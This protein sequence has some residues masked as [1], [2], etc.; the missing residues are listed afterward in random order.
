MILK[1]EDSMPFFKSSNNIKL[2]KKGSNAHTVHIY[3]LLTVWETMPFLQCNAK[4]KEP[5]QCS[6]LQRKYVFL[7]PNKAVRDKGRQV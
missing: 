7:Q 5:L 6:S 1:I 2:K 3:F 4:N